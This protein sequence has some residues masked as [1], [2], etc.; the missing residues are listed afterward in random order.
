MLRSRPAIAPT[1]PFTRTSSANCAAF[2]RSPSRTFA[3]VA[4]L[5]SARGGGRPADQRQLRRLPGRHPPGQLGDI[6]EARSLE[7]AGRG[8]RSISA[9]TMHEQR[10]VPWQLAQPVLESIEGYRDTVLDASGVVLAGRTNVDEQHLAVCNEFR[11]Q[12]RTE[13][14]RCRRQVGA[15]LETGQTALEI[16]LDVIEADAAKAK[17]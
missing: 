11:R 16:A 7:K 12:R 4:E 1:N 6:G 9:G 15:A 2:A 5:I 10:P 13:S 14:R 8:R 17:R 3:V